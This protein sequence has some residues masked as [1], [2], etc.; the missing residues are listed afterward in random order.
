M[1]E[2]LIVGL[3]LI[4]SIVFMGAVFYKMSQV[5]DAHKKE[6]GG[7]SMAKYI[8][9]SCGYVG[10]KKK[11][12]KGSFWSELGLWILSILMLIAGI[13]LPL[14][15]LF[16]AI[17]IVVAFLYSVYRCFFAGTEVCP[18]CG[19]EKSMIPLDSPMGKELYNKLYGEKQREE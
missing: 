14:L 11:K 6:R 8:C 5:A 1:A 18:K 16:G 10:K 15:F 7:A 19:A 9:S 3:V 4:A 12:V 17:L 13:V 2:L